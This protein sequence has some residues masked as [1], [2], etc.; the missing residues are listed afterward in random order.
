M[1]YRRKI[2]VTLCT[3]AIGLT[4]PGISTAT[5]KSSPGTFAGDFELPQ[6]WNDDFKPGPSCATP[7]SNGIYPIA[8]RRWF[9]QTDAA[10]VANHNNHPVPVKQHIKDVRTQT[11]ETSVQIKEKAELPKLMTNTFGFNY[12]YTEHWALKQVVGPYNL[13][14]GKQGR[15]VWGFLI[16]DT[17]NQNVTCGE[18]LTWH[19]VGAPFDASIPESRYSEL[20]V[21]S[22]I[23]E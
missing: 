6:R 3:L 18:D 16:L 23:E 5:E 17:T 2:A 11:V 4:T 7:N 21:D 9:K 19:E 22:T 12:V 10:S 15:L 20:R 1:R 8:K 14:A 13:P